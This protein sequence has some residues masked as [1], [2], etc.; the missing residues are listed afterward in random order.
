MQVTIAFF[1]WTGAR[2]VKPSL[3]AGMSGIRRIAIDKAKTI[4][5]MGEEGRVYAT[6]YLIGDIEMTCRNLILEHADDGEDSVGIEVAVKHLAPALPGSNVE[7]TATVTAVEGRKVT[8]AV[9]ARDEIDTVSSGTYARFVVDKA[10]TIERLK[11]KA[12]KLR[13]T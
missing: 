2:I 1:D 12:A 5:F 3:K 8:F 10:K 13:P 7:I 9:T 11:A 4:S 6:P